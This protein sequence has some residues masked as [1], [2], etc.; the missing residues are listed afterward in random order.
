MISILIIHKQNKM[1]PLSIQILPSFLHPNEC[2]DLIG[3]FDT[4]ESERLLTR[5]RI[6]FQDQ[7]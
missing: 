7:Q 4:Q 1:Q 3:H 5:E 2:K 6:Q